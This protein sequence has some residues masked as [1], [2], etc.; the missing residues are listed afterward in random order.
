[1]INWRPK[2]RKPDSNKP[3]TRPRG[4]PPVKDWPEQI[5]DTPKNVLRAV[6]AMAGQPADG[7]RYMKA[8]AKQAPATARKP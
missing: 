2:V 8:H 7:W 1:M 6:L 3:P 4:R 5:P